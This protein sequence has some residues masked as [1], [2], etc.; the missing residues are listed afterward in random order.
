MVP[1]HRWRR[2]VNTGKTD[3]ILYSY[4]DQPLIAKLGHYR[5]QGRSK[6]GAVVDLV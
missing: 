5:A 2:F 6:D 1:N 3:A 4:T